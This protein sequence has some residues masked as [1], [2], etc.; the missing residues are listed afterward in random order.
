MKTKRFLEL[1]LAHEGEYCVWANRN[2]RVQQTFHAS[3]DDLLQVGR[4]LD[5]NGWNA[6][7]AMGTFFDSSSREATNVQWMKS[8]YLDLDCGPDKEFPSQAVAIDELRTFCENNSLPTPTLVNSGRGVHVYWILSEPVCR[9][10][11]WPVAER[12]KMLCKDQG[13]EADPSRTS[14]AAFCAYQTHVTTSM[15]NHYL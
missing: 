14:D 3:I 10:D 2:G 8:F 15:G 13:F 11:W 5:S 7:F 6:F 9:E 1:I 4:D 12:L